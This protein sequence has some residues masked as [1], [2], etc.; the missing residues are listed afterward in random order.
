MARSL[1]ERTDAFERRR[2][3]VLL[4]G[5]VAFAAWQIIECVRPLVPSARG[6]LA[7]A[8]VAAT[9]VWVF[10][11]V[12]ELQLTRSLKRDPDL[13]SATQDERVR[14]VRLRALA[15]GFWAVLLLQ[16]LALG[17]AA[18][19]FSVSAMVSARLTLA[20]GILTAS[21]AFVAFER[22]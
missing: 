8:A 10:S 13:T 7:L 9:A 12:R 16:A 20:F 15:L 14:S 21:V 4:V 3:H 11:I 22:E 5:G 18:F 1:S 19:G 17:A 2:T 6:P